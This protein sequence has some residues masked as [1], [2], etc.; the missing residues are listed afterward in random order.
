MPSLD[1][2]DTD[3]VLTD[4]LQSPSPTSRGRRRFLDSV[5]KEYDSSSAR[6]SS[7]VELLF[8]TIIND[9]VEKTQF[10]KPS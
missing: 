7:E 4:M 9:V 6:D 3:E 5:K 1:L 8:M 2:L 10:L